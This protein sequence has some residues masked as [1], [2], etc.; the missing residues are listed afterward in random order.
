VIANH[1]GYGTL[2]LV[3]G[4]AAFVALV[5]FALR[6]PETAERGTPAE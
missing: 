5:V 2:L 6:M 3:A 4:R 1:F